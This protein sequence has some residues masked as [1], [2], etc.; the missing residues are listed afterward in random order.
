MIFRQMGQA[1][2]T[3]LPVPTVEIFDD[4]LPKGRRI[5]AAE[6]DADAIGIGSWDIERFN[7]TGLAKIVL[8]YMRIK[9]IQI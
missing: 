1:C 3:L 2:S 9:G 6:I 5:N 7:A 8:R 4:N